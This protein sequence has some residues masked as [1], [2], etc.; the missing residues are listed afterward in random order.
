MMKLSRRLRRHLSRTAYLIATM[1]FGAYVLTR[2]L[3]MSD[4]GFE[5][6]WSVLGDTL[7]LPMF[8]LAIV[9]SA[10]DPSPRPKNRWSGRLNPDYSGAVAIAVMG[11]SASLILWWNEAPGGSAVVPIIVA[12]ATILGTVAAWRFAKQRG[13]EIGEARFVR[14]ADL[15]TS[16]RA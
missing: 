7:G 9:G 15:S 5:E 11:F 10:L 3:E 8:L 14:P 16:P 13:A 4:P 2:Y 1:A 12:V 6:R